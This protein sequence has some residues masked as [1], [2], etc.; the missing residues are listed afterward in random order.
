[1][2]ELLV[3]IAIIA[4]LAAMLLPALGK[5]KIKAQAIGCMNN[6]RQITLAW[7]MYA[8]DNDDRV[9]GS[10][11]WLL[12]DGGW[13]ANGGVYTADAID[14]SLLTGGKLNS[15]LGGN[16][17]VYKCPGDRGTYAGQ[18][19]LRSVSMQSAIGA[20][21]SGGAFWN[22]NYLW[23]PK[24]S[25]MSRPGP[26]NIFVLVDEMRNTINDDFFAVNMN[27]YDPLDMSLTAF[28]DVPATYHNK[29][30]SVSFADGHSEIRK[31]RDPRTETARL[32]E[33]SP[34]N[35]DIAWF[36]DRTS[37]KIVNPTR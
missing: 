36:Q 23:Y 17:A 5:A 10:R 9:C 20:N 32:F 37:R 19:V 27:G 21:A 18:P 1:L 22:G 25:T 33:A 28:V 24:L 12:R 16:I 15:H 34:N 26:A 30:G 31:W 3:V 7:I 13:I 35:R 4:I 6:T 29:A 14:A 2:I 8:H 11:N